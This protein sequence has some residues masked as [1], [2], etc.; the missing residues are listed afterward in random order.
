[1]K[2]I[3]HRGNIN[4]IVPE[5]ENRPSYIDC[6]LQ[7]GY[8]VEVDIRYIKNSFYLGHDT[9][10]FEVS[11]VWIQSRK[12][13]IWFHCK[14]SE[15]AYQLFLL[16]KIKYFCH[17]I[18]PYVLTS[19]NH[20]WVH[21]LSMITD[22]SIIPLLDLNSIITYQKYKNVYAICTDYVDYIKTK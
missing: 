9:P 17:S 15:A 16:D 22:H 21:D 12:D 10:D 13:N 11:D 19:T 18:D 6:A 8:D 1:M 5:K 14:N 20:I 3:S 4:G 7:L 2:I